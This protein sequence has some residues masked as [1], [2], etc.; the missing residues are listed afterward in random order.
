[1]PRIYPRVFSLVCK[2]SACGFKTLQSD[3][4]HW[5]DCPGLSAFEDADPA[6]FN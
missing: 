3:A 1:M 2:P 6:R 5:G 4:K